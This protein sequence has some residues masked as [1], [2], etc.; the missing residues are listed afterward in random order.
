MIKNLIYNFQRL[1]LIEKISILIF[2]LALIIGFILR[3]ALSFQLFRFDFDQARDAFLYQE[4]WQGR[5]VYLG[6]ASA[7]GGYSLPPLYYYFSFPFTIFGS[8]IYYT[9]VFNI[10]FSFLSIVSIFFLCWSVLEGVSQKTKFVISSTASLWWS[11][12]FIDVIHSQFAWNPNST[13][14]F[15][16]VYLML[17]YIITKDITASN[18]K[19]NF[20]KLSQN[21]GYSTTNSD[22]N[23]PNN[24][25]L[26][27]NAKAV[28]KAMFKRIL[29]LVVFGVLS[30][31]LISLHSSN[32]FILIPF[33][34]V[35]F[36]FW[37]F[38][39]KSLGKR[40]AIWVAPLA[41]FLV[42]TPY[43]IGEIKNNWQNSKNIL[44]LVTNSKLDLGIRGK[45]TLARNSLVWLFDTT[46]F[47]GRL[48]DNLP[49]VGYFLLILIFLIFCGF[50]FWR[51]KIKPYW[52][53]SLG[54]IFALYLYSISN[55]SDFIHMHYQVMVW[56]F[57]MLLSL[58]CLALPLEN[59]LQ[60]TNKTLFL[61]S[62]KLAYFNF[63]NFAC[64]S[65]FCIFL[66]LSLGLNLKHN[67][68]YQKLKFIDQ[69]I[70]TVKDT[71]E[72]LSYV[73]DQAKVCVQNDR[74]LPYSYITQKILSKKVDFKKIENCLQANYQVYQ[75]YTLP[76]DM[77]QEV[78]H[79]SYWHEVKAQKNTQKPVF[80]NKIQENTAFILYQK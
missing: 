74:I 76:K 77:Y 8:S 62:S 71:K 6:P 70:P 49:L 16:A 21:Q 47:L 27:Q 58:V 51:L 19:I 26:N 52:V 63:I 45:F 22:S 78:Q 10:L 25:I 38:K 57:P 18:S 17:G 1:S 61:Q 50:A 30:A 41:S 64:L 34:G 37:I 3:V 33:T 79:Y 65:G 46:L 73:P 36:L 53:F 14:F 23:L 56:F 9:V 32:L 44:Y 13:P 28:S 55:Y 24:T 7:I 69:R 20:S 39:S 59:L 66:S 31:L 67:L 42:L 80:S 11:L 68:Q 4:M 60:N 12:F 43:W 29:A 2:I 54:I 40:L 72:I 5:P 48:N 75:K 35:L 15:L